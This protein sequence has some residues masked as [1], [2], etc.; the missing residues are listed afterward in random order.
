MTTKD[1]LLKRV[2][3]LITLAH[4]TVRRAGTGEYDNYRSRLRSQGLSFLHSLSGTSHPNYSEFEQNS[5]QTN[6]HFT[7]NCRH[8]LHGDKA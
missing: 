2:D 8:I 4:E 1:V 7:E 5:R 6:V 3:D